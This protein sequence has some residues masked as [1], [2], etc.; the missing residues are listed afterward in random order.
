M[1]IIFIAKHYDY[2]KNRIAVVA[3]RQQFLFI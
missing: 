2:N 3:I 1:S